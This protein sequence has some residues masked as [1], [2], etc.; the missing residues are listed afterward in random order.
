[1]KDQKYQWDEFCMAKKMKML[2]VWTYE[3]S[4]RNGR[5]VIEPREFVDN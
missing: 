3:F 2:N 1:M 5:P 4:E